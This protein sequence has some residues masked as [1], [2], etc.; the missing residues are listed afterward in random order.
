MKAGR[1]LLKKAF[2]G[3]GMLAILVA[4]G[5]AVGLSEN[6][7]RA[8]EIFVG[9]QG[10]APEVIQ[11][12]KKEAIQ[13]LVEQLKTEKDLDARMQIRVA[14]KVYL[15]SHAGEVDPSLSQLADQA[16]H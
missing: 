15:M 3:A 1:F 6:Q 12:F 10:T 4:R 9:T 5:D 8:L 11:G 16:V 2:A 7:T 13:A 14:L